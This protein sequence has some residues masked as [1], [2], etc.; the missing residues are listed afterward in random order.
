MRSEPRALRIQRK[1]GLVS[2]D[3]REGFTSG[4]TFELDLEGW[5]TGFLGRGN[6]LSRGTEQKVAFSGRQGTG[7]GG[8]SRADGV[9]SV[10]GE[11]NTAGGPGS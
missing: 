5:S 2:S 10:P 11:T 7:A 4:V 9:S 6:S 3:P 8:Q 1:E